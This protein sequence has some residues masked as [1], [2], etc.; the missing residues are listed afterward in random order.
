M[1]IG[2]DSIRLPKRRSNQPA[3]LATLYPVMFKQSMN[4]GLLVSLFGKGNQLKVQK[5]SGFLPMLDQKQ[6]NLS[7]S[8][9]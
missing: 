3:Y 2:R 5:G 7:Y 6:R 4:W 1:E 9:H 8:C